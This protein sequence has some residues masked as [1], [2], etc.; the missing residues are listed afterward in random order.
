MQLLAE[1]R[2]LRKIRLRVFTT[3]GAEIPIR[4]GLYQ[5]PEAGHQDFILHNMP[6]LPF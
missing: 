3:S 1:A 5:I 2:L 6:G 4:H